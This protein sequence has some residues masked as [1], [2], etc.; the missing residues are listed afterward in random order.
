MTHLRVE[1]ANQHLAVPA[2]ACRC[3]R[4]LRGPVRHRRAPSLEGKN[5]GNGGKQE[6]VWKERLI[7]CK[8]F[9]FNTIS[10]E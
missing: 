10:S 9:F 7:I 6:F 8:N 1:P 4:V 5:H 2:T 3:R